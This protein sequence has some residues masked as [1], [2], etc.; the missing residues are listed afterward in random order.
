MRNV[1][2]GLLCVVPG[3]DEA[4]E[5][6]AEELELG[7][8]QVCEGHFYEPDLPPRQQ[9]V[10]DVVAEHGCVTSK[11]VAAELQIDRNTALK[12]LS[13]LVRAGVLNSRLVGGGE[14]EWSN[15]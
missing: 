10:R 7:M 6:G 1:G 14:L 2:T 13:A 9:K 4:C 15:R 8:P 11:V 5:L 3:C 12:A